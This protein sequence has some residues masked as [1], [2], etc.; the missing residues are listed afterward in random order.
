M[1]APLAPPASISTTSR[2]RLERGAPKFRGLPRAE[3]PGST[4]ATPPLL[5]F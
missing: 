1:S 3:L 4:A 5:P 2:S